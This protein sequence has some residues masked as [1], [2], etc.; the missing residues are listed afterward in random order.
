MRIPDEELGLK[1][2]HCYIPVFNHNYSREN[3]TIIIGSIIMK[4]YYLS[5]D[6]SPLETGKSYIHVAMGT[7]NPTN[8]IRAKQYNPRSS[9]YFPL[10]SKTDSSVAEKDL[11]PWV[12]GG[13]F[14]KE[15]NSK[16]VDMAYA[17]ARIRGNTVIKFQGSMM[18]KYSE[19]D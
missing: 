17:S 10:D 19:L 6:M 12:P 8:V 4:K 18:E 11:P 5:F 16:V 3:E 15:F 13:E 2:N 1:D 14:I 7:K 9:S